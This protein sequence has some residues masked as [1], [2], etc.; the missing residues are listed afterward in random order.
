MPTPFTHLMVAQRLSRDQR[1]PR[2]IRD[3]ILREEPAF[4]LGSV[5]ADG[6]VDLGSE[7][8][9]THFYR[10]DR[11]QTERAWRS[12]LRQHPSLSEADSVSH[13]VFLAA[14]VAHLAAD[15]EWTMRM[16][17]PHF[18]EREWRGGESRNERFRRL[19]YLLSWMDER[20]WMRL[21]ETCAARLSAAKPANWLPFFSDDSM[22]NWRDRI[23]QQL[24]P[25]GVSET[26]AVFGRRIGQAPELIRARLDDEGWMHQ[27]LWR[28]IPQSLL[29][30][31][32]ES[33][34]AEAVEQLLAY[35]HESERSW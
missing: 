29:G 11:P 10:Y 6:R 22:R 3:T 19:H 1:V 4:L 13:R 34:Q 24:P 7:R 30:D 32:E 20:D 31:I 9:E 18:A 12:M 16:L 26:L 23:A 27:H 28:N 25:T 33:L 8:Q 2:E 15:E 17:R 21:D 35:W 14:Y 5:A